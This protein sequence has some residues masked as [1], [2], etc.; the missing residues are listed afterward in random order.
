MQQAQHEHTPSFTNAA[1]A[2]QVASL[3]ATCGTQALG[4]TWR[5]FMPNAC[6]SAMVAVCPKRV[7]S[8]ESEI[9]DDKT[10]GK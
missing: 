4:M 6:T 3:R 5:Q 2:E 9:H 1:Y 10:G 8:H 7:R